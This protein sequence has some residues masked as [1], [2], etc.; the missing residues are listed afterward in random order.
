VPYACDATSLYVYAITLNDHNFFA[1]S[2]DLRLTLV[3]ELD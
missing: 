1:A 3:A 2:T